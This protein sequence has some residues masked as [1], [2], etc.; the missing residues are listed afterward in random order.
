MHH[1]SIDNFEIRK[2][3]DEEIP[4]ALAFCLKVFKEYESPAYPPEGT[5]EFIRSIHDKNYLDGIEY[6]GAFDNDRLIGVIGFRRNRMHLCFFFVDGS[7]H[8]RGIGTEMFRYLLE[9]YPRETITVNSAPYGLPFYQRL[10]FKPTDHEQVVNGIRF[11]P[12]AYC[13]EP[14]VSTQ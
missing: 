6:Y 7:Y 3:R 14:S 12:M 8:R 9:A 5:E 4:E 11:T 1:D 13:P 2:L 10:G